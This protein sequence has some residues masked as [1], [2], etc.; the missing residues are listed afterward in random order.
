MDSLYVYSSTIKTI[1]ALLYAKIAGANSVNEAPKQTKLNCLL[2]VEAGAPAAAGCP[3]LGAVVAA[4]LVPSSQGAA[5]IGGCEAERAV[6]A[7]DGRVGPVGDGLGGA[8]HVGGL[9]LHRLQRVTLGA[10][11]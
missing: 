10:D 2:P 3:P 5:P 4:V 8:A 1:S 7:V 9:P 6:L 11:S